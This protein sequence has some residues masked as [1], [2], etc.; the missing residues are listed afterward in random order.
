MAGISAIHS[1]LAGIQNGM[2]SVRKDA[3]IIAS[4][5]IAS[6]TGVN[7]NDTSKDL[8]DAI[9]DMKS[10]QHQVEASVQV[11]KTQDEIL[12]TLLDELA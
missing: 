4:Q 3:H 6:V 11:I 5:T 10:S 9:I 12:G 7:N 8:T 1:G 2:N